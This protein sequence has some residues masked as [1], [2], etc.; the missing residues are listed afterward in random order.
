MIRVYSGNFTKNDMLIIAH[1]LRSGCEQNFIS[2]ACFEC[3]NFNVY[4]AL[5]KAADYCE[6]KARK[7]VES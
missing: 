4:K 6:R 1:V 3:D 7:M 2:R 5:N